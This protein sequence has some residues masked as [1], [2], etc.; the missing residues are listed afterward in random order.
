MIMGRI[1]FVAFRS[2]GKNMIVQFAS[3]QIG[4]D[5]VIASAHSR[6]LAKYGWKGSR[7]N[8]PAAY[9]TGLLAGLRAAR[10][11]CKKSLMYSGI[12][13]Y[14]HGSR[15]A[16]ATKGVI[17]GGVEVPLQEEK[18]L[19]ENRIRGLH[20]VEYAR[21]LS[22]EGKEVPRKKF[23]GLVASGLNPEDYPKHFEEV[24]IRIESEFREK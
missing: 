11:G 4:G 15:I 24:K 18:V 10:K 6:E 19:D 16:A 17:D 23:S 21:L 12:R 9:L 5:K 20:I 8:T 3:A 13:P 1:P 22:Q 14:V 2:G 7:K